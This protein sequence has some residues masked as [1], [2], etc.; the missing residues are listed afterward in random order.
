MMNKCAYCGI[1][2]E[3]TFIYQE[4][5]GKYSRSPSETFCSL[6]HRS[7]WLLL[8]ETSGLRNEYEIQRSTKD[9]NK[10]KPC[11][12]VILTP[13]EPCSLPAPPASSRLRGSDGRFLS[14]KPKAETKNKKVLHCSP[15]RTV[16]RIY[17]Y[18]R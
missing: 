13:P 9:L 5:P 8:K 15:K 3:S 14:A 4:A 17:H 11:G 10:S 16:Y 7:L 18:P 6:F 2:C 1:F 12:E